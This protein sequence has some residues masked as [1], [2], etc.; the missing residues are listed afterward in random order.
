MLRRLA[1]GE[2]VRQSTADHEGSG[3]MAHLRPYLPQLAV[4]EQACRRPI[5]E[6]RVE[7]L[8]PSLDRARLLPAGDGEGHR[9]S[10]TEAGL[11][12]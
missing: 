8:E 11:G 7:A 9:E 6:L 2:E 5:V 1:L 10:L 3:C 4:S 12:V